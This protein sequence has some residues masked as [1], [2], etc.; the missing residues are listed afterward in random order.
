VK[1]TVPLNSISNLFIQ[2]CK[3]RRNKTNVLLAD[4]DIHAGQDILL[5]YLGVADGQTVSSLVEKMNIQHSTIF[6]M[7]DRMEATGMIRKEKDSADKRTSRIYLTEQ[8]TAALAKVVVVWRTME[9]ETI[10]GFDA[11]ETEMLRSLLQKVYKNLA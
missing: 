10:K 6:N 8:G 9:A 4:A 11:G 7:I 3:L 1:A 2:I 5:Y